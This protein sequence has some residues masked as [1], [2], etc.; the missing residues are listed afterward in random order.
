M[1]SSPQTLVLSLLWVLSPVCICPITIPYKG[2]TQPQSS[3]S[4]LFISPGPT[5][6]LHDLTLLGCPL[7]E[8]SQGG[9]FPTDSPSCMQLS[10]PC[11]LSFHGLTA[12][13]VLALNKLS[14]YDYT[15]VGL[16]INYWRTSLLL[17]IW[18]KYASS[19]Y[20]QNWFQVLL[21]KASLKVAY[22]K[23]ALKHLVLLSSLFWFGDYR[24]AT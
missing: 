24:Y 9:F 13:S 22:I 14:L 3:T 1:E 20:A 17:L 19:I 7:L 11:L 18:G 21:P 10:F 4:F 15:T 5:S 16:L 6:S 23:A 8:S 12:Q 2:V